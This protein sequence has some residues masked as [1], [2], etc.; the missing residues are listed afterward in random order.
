MSTESIFNFI[1]IDNRIGTGGQ[2]TAQQLQAARNEGYEA[3]INLAPSNADNHALPDEPA[4]VASLGLT[5]HHIPVEWTNPRQEQFIAFTEAMNQLRGK[6]VFIHCAANFR[7][8][9]FFSLYA[10]KHEGWTAEQADQL[11]A[12]IW[13]SRSDYR[14]D[15]TWKSFIDDTRAQVVM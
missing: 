5:Y 4:V 10:M 14:M 6:K 2:P 3:I 8:T 11:I 9:A 1:K 13:E 12:K 7:V 15:S